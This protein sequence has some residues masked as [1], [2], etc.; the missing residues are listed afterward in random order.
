M[1]DEKE[2]LEQELELMAAAEAGKAAAR[3]AWEG[4]K[5]AVGGVADS[6][7]G[8]AERELAAAEAARGRGPLS[9]AP[10]E[11][12][13]QASERALESVRRAAPPG[14]G[15]SA[16]ARRRAREAR[17]RE[18]LE[19]LKQAHAE[20]RPLRPPPEPEEE[21]E[22]LPARVAPREETPAVRRSLDGAEDHPAQPEDR[23]PAKRTL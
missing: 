23:E 14:A 6:V 18:Q 16:M 17:A 22:I 5:A 7:L 2:K 13:S 12:A 9:R 10:G 3:S 1:A 8:R 20:G 21:E 19:A 15:E 4:V 11:P